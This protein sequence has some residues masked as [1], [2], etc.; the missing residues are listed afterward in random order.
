MKSFFVLLTATLFAGVVTAGA[1][2][3]DVV[4]AELGVGRLAK[5]DSSGILLSSRSTPIAASIAFDSGGNS[6][7]TGLMAQYVSRYDSSGH[8][9][10][11]INPTLIDGEIPALLGGS[12][13]GQNDDFYLG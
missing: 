1:T 3:D 10:S 11:L 4:L 6:Y 13:F 8:F 9:Q 12:A 2:A 5:F 7:V